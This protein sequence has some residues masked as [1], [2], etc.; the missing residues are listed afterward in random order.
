MLVAVCK[1][2]RLGSPP[3][4]APPSL[5]SKKMAS[6]ETAGCLSPCPRCEEQAGI[7]KGC[8]GS[9]GQATGTLQGDRIK[10]S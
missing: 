9:K 1:E 4:S 5:R 7:P 2:A 6:E 10:V 3:S 8:V